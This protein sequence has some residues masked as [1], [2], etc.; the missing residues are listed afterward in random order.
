MK[1][2]FTFSFIVLA[3]VISAAGAAPV[4][5]A[6]CVLGTAN[7][8]PC[9]AGDSTCLANA[10]VSIQSAAAGGINID[11]ATARQGTDNKPTADDEYSGFMQKIMSLFAWLVGVAALTLDYAV[12]YTVVTMGSYVNNLSAVGVTWQIMRDIGNIIFIFGFIAIGICTILRVEWYGGGTKMLPMLIVGAIFLNFSLFISEAIIDTGNLFATQFYT[13][14]K[15]GT[16]PTAASLSGTGIIDAVE[17]DGISNKIMGQLGLQTIYTAGRVNTEVFKA[18]NSF[19]IGFMGIILFLITAFVLFSLAF[20]LI[21]RFVILLLLI[22]VAPIGFAGLAIPNL[23]GTAKMWWDKLIQQT[24]TAPVLLLLLYIAL[25]II[26]DTKFLT[27]FGSGTNSGG[28]TGWIRSAT[29][30]D[31]LAGFGI[32]MISFLV[33]MGLL[34]YVVIASKQLSA[35]GADKA[36]AL[37]GKLTFGATAFA[38]RRTV[39]RVSNYAARKVR[40]TK[41]GA[42]ETGR[43]LAGTFDRGAKASFDVRGIKAGGGLGA[44]RVDAGE[45]QKGGYRAR[46]DELIKVRTDYAKSL[47]QSKG[48]KE[49]TEAAQTEHD[50]NMAPLQAAEQAQLD[51]TKQIVNASR[52]ELKLK[53]QELDAARKSGNA[54]RIK[55]AEAAYNNDMNTHKE[56]VEAERG[57]LDPIRKNMETEKSKLEGATAQNSVAANQ[58]KYG[59]ALQSGPVMKILRAPYD[60]PTAVGSARREA[61]SKIISESKKTKEQKNIDK[62]EEILAK[63]EGK[64]DSGGGGKKPAEE[65]P[66][67]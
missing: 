45:A 34:L 4:A 39:G 49:A 43:L 31:N 56:L 58:R 3:L 1:R 51:S 12:Y 18:G 6:D 19:L 2:I 13:Q 41:W 46:E 30:T 25:R 42:S 62:L 26:T 32:I 60:W 57:K 50:K 20:V 16:L 5:H 7:C 14:I 23:A 33:A 63:S 54:N 21:A 11:P 17:R 36:S 10:Q 55:T 24:I 29:G 52:E 61:A 48:Q 40:S 27:G 35:F 9:P 44:L 65:K 64:I 22:I 59:E 15:G 47:R 66:K 8:D 67:E 53:K 38:G 28:W 37:A